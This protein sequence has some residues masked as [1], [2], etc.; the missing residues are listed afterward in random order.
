M[1]ERRGARGGG[2]RREGMHAK[3][4]LPPSLP[5]CA[6]LTVA[7]G[8][9]RMRFGGALVRNANVAGRGE[10][11]RAPGAR[12]P[13]PAPTRPPP[14]HHTGRRCRVSSTHLVAIARQP[15]SAG[16]G[17]TVLAPSSVPCPAPIKNAAWTA[18][19]GGASLAHVRR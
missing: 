6:C 18:G 4:V 15:A 8:G 5:Q 11:P 16:I 12:A 10:R 7:S 3:A 13:V 19:S 2:R 9:G 14:C 17:V 1:E